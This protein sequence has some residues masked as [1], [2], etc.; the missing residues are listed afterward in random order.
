METAERNGRRDLE[1]EKF[2]RGA[3]QEHGG[4]GKSVRQFCVEKGL[5]VGQFYAWRRELKLRGAEKGGAGGFVEL[6]R[7]NAK[8]GAGVSIRVDDQM[9]VVL[10][11]GFDVE[12]LKGALACLCAEAGGR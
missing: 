5:N 9:S 7:S 8:N 2:W 10:E 11:R 3:V 1:K 4:T 12:T 6:I